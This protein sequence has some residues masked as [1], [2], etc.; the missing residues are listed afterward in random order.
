MKRTLSILLS[1]V[2]AVSSLGAGTA[3]FANEQKKTTVEYSVYDG[4]FTKEPTKIEVT[5]DL[6]DKYG[7]SDEGSEPTVLDATIAAHLDMLGSTES[8]SVSGGW[9]NSA[10]GKEAGN[11]SYRVSGM[12]SG[13][14]NDKV[15]NGDFI[16]YM[17]YQDTVGWSD[18]YTYFNTRSEEIFIGEGVALTLT[19]EGYDS[20]RNPVIE[21]AANANVTVNGEV[22][23]TTDE[24]GS[25]TLTFDKSGTYKI[26]TE[27]NTN[28]AKIFAPWCE[29]RVDGELF[30]YVQ[31]ETKGAATYLLNGVKTFTVD[32]AVDYLTYLKSGYDMSKFNTAF[33]ASVKA[34]LDANGGKFITPAVAGYKS[35]MGIYGAVIQI[36]SLLDMN[37]ANFEGYNL[38]EAFEGLDLTASY[39]PY[40]YRAAIEAANETFAKTLCDKYSTD[41]YVSGSGLNYWG[42]SC[43]NTAHFLTAIAKY[44]NDYAQYVDDAKAVIKTYTKENGAFCNAQ[45]TPDVNADSTALAMMAYASIGELGTAFKYYKNLVEGF[46]SNKAGV[47]CYS[48]N[49]NANAY[50]TKDALLSLEYF[51][52]EVKTKKFEHPE[53]VIKTA[54]TKATTKKN[55]NITSACAICGKISKK[56]TIY[57]PKKITL[58]TSAYT[59][60]GKAKQPKVTVTDSKGNKISSKNYTAK[61][62]KNTKVGTAKVTLTFKGNYS[63]SLSKT[64][65]INPKS[66]KLSKVSAGKKSFTAKWSKQSAQT[67]GYQL[68]YAANK[69]FTKSKVTK[70]VSKNKTTSKKISGLK[71]NKK[72]YVRIRTYKVVDGKKYYSKWS[73]AKSV[74]AKK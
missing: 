64:F 1:L 61:Y 58:S 51:K 39:N 70:T 43:D 47:F 56:T 69:K 21:R 3:V 28:G 32:N 14:L 19:K 22:K 72:Y 53:E 23:G 52:D 60:S 31:S 12:Y 13:G 26:S 42:F 63:G 36:L 24:N 8:F 49:A 65:K 6:S 25:V 4:E 59:Y 34:N 5:A 73:S 20:Y 9:T 7:Y 44:K 62:S 29:I 41:F 74:T 67:T 33:L 27:N 68:Q 40:Y 37:P 71:A 38:V 30:E 57:Y 66:T 50:A 48:D 16:E 45:Y 35:E 54:V 2:L 15:K 10:F 18:S 55:G 11:F 17:F 46:E